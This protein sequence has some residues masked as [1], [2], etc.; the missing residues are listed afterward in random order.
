MSRCRGVAQSLLSVLQ[1]LAQ[2]DSLPESVEDTH[3]L[4]DQHE[5][6]VRHAFDDP[7]L[8]QVQSE[9]KGVLHKLRDMGETLKYCHDYR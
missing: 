7:H 1:E 5:Q 6:C 9:A 4:I 3:K 2:L 8:V